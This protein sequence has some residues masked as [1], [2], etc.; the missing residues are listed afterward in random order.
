MVCRLRLCNATQSARASASATVP[1]ASTSTASGSPKINVDVIGSKPS[2]SPKGFGRSPTIAFPG[3][4][5]MF[6]VSVFDAT[7][8]V[9][10][11]VSFSPFLPSIWYS[12]RCQSERLFKESLAEA[13]RRIHWT[14]VSI[15]T[16]VL[17]GRCGQERASLYPNG[18]RSIC[19]GGNAMKKMAAPIPFAGFQLDQTC[20]VSA[21]FNSA[22]EEYRVLLP[23]G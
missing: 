14:N 7:G 9:T 3:A 13:R 18:R 16:K 17:V 1:I 22:D 6:T 10:R 19:C 23:W 20:H 15:D 21:F 2:G 11:V 5:K 4:V 12:F 8:A